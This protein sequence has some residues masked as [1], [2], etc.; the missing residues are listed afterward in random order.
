LLLENSLKHRTNAAGQARIPTTAAKHAEVA[1]KHLAG[2]IAAG[3]KKIYGFGRKSNCQRQYRKQHDA[4]MGRKNYRAIWN[5]SKRVPDMM[6]LTV[7]AKREDCIIHW[8][9][10]ILS[11][12]Q[13][14]KT[15]SDLGC[16]G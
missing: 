7:K 10:S 5:V 3:K 12:Q 2:H 4:I 8:K 11:C 13:K 15:K 16:A 9:R 14:A 6:I 1:E